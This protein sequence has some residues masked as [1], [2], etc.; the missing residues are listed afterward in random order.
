MVQTAS[1]N[2]VQ[3]GSSPG[4]GCAQTQVA[5]GLFPGISLFQNDVGTSSSQQQVTVV[6]R[7]ERT[8]PSENPD[9]H[10]SQAGMRAN[11]VSMISKPAAAEKSAYPSFTFSAKNASN[12]K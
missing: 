11:L 9:S 2:V 8:K 7:E 5:A 1:Q 6:S 3:S 10:E 12:K 4:G